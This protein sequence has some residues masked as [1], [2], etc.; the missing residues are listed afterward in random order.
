MYSSNVER[1]WFQGV[2]PRRRIYENRL[3]NFLI[4]HFFSWW[5]SL[6]WNNM[7]ILHATWFLCKKVIWLNKYLASYL[8]G[9]IREPRLHSLCNSGEQTSSIRFHQHAV[10][11]TDK[12][13]ISSF[14]PVFQLPKSML[15]CFL[16]LGDFSSILF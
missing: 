7:F 10:H 11:S 5:A 3:N 16:Q 9:I 13:L 1:K 14:L 8:R 2:I 12:Y 4:A 6:F 15:K